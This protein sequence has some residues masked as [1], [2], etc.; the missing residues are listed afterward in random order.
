MAEITEREVKSLFNEFKRAVR[1]GGTFSE[2]RL[3]T[4]I[5]RTSGLSVVIPHYFLHKLCDVD[6]DSIPGYLF[7]KYKIAENQPEDEKERWSL[8]KIYSSVEKALNELMKE[9]GNASDGRKP[10]SKNYD[11]KVRELIVWSAEL[12]F[13]F[14][15]QKCEHSPVKRF[16]KS[17]AVELFCEFFNP[18][19]GTDE[20]RFEVLA[21][22]DCVDIME[23]LLCPELGVS[24]SLQEYFDE[25]GNVIRFC[26]TPMSQGMIKTVNP[27]SKKFYIIP[28]PSDRN[29]FAKMYGIVVCGFFKPDQADYSKPEQQAATAIEDAF[30]KVNMDVIDTKTDPQIFESENLFTELRKW[31]EDK[32]KDIENG[33]S[34]L[35]LTVFC[36]GIYGHLAHEVEGNL[37]CMAIE[38][39]FKLFNKYDGL[40]EIPKVSK[41]FAC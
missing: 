24:S 15:L 18:I 9:S 31:V 34:L 27:H 10:E 25:K 32:L 29:N 2:E 19:D 14:N 21:E 35:V 23:K 26:Q 4:M 6:I 40:K 20:T 38:E 12:W 16:I 22:K 39:L 5:E 28:R 33:C 13:L 41:I 11:Q 36:H 37:L 3:N 8:P 1:Q 7:K 17:N 30:K